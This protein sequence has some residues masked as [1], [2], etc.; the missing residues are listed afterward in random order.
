MIYVNPDN[1]FTKEGIKAVNE[2]I[3]RYLYFC[4]NLLYHPIYELKLK[5]YLKKIDIN[6]FI[7]IC[8]YYNNKNKNLLVN[9]ISNF[10]KIYI[11]KRLAVLSIC[12]DEY[13]KSFKFV[14][15]RNLEKFDL[16]FKGDENLE[17]K[18]EKFL[19]LL[20]NSNVNYDVLSTDVIKVVDKN[21]RVFFY[22]GNRIV[23]FDENLDK[24]LIIWEYSRGKS[25]Y[26][27]INENNLELTLLYNEI[28]LDTILEF[29]EILRKSLERNI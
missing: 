27:N 29:L 11:Y 7:N 22:Y 4:E 1:S 5:Q 12:P 19:K 20:S 13:A 9:S 8:K 16:D 3:N 25:L 18:Y 28:D 2:G 10:L 6:E 26:E 23:V 15:Y 14:E 24:N 17:L 21:N